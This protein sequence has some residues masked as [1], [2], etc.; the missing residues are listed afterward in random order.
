MPCGFVV[1]VKA[2]L[3]AV[4]EGGT[5]IREGCGIVRKKSSDD[6][7]TVPVRRLLN[8]DGSEQGRHQWV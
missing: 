2:S 7:D 3:Q 8:F 1:R 5:F 6:M 4:S